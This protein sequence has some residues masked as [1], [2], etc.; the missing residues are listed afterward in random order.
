MHTHIRTYTHTIVP[1]KRC[2]ATQSVPTSCFETWTVGR[3]TTA[4]V[5]TFHRSPC[6]NRLPESL[7]CRVPRD[8]VW[9]TGRVVTRRGGC[10]GPTPWDGSRPT[11]SSPNGTSWGRRNETAS[12]V[13]PHP[14]SSCCYA[15]DGPGTVTRREFVSSSVRRPSEGL[16]YMKNNNI[17][18]NN[19]EQ[20]E[21]NNN[22]NAGIEWQQ[23]ERKK[24]YIR[25]LH[26]VKEEA[27]GRWCMIREEKRGKRQKKMKKEKKISELQ[28]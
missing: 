24:K 22:N 23:G 9:R 13:H 15:G 8:V 2:F 18:N 1:C 17:D 19:K 12:K 26:D 7:P 10:S 27:G 14:A 28:Q 6:D 11:S 5:S 25:W 20:Q 21:H 16:V 3:S 4:V